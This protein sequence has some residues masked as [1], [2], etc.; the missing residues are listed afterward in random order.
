MII[1]TSLNRRMPLRLLCIIAASLGVAQILTAK[2]LQVT[3][4][5]HQ[6]IQYTSEDHHGGDVT[7]KIAQDRNANIYVASE[8]GALKFN[9]EEW[10]ILPPS[11]QSNHI[12]SILV[13]DSNNIW[14]AGPKHVGF[15]SCDNAGSY[16]FND[17]T[18]TFLKANKQQSPAAFWEILKL[19]NHIYLVSSKEVARWEGKTWK[20]WPFDD[21]R[22]ILPSLSN[23]NL[24]IHARGSGLYK[25]L[26]DD[27]K[28]LIGNSPEIES[29]IMSA[30]EMPN[31]ELLCA[32]LTNGLFRL[33]ERSAIPVQ[34]NFKTAGIFNAIKLSD[35]TIAIATFYRGILISSS[36]GQLIKEIPYGSPVYR[37]KEDRFGSIWAATTDSILH[38]PNLELIKFSDNAHG[39]SRFNNAIYY[40]NKSQLKCIEDKRNT[41]QTLRNIIE[42]TGLRE[43]LPTRE[44]LLYASLS[45][46]GTVSK[47]GI[48][49]ETP[50]PRHIVALY[51]SKLNPNIIY[52]SEPPEISRWKI[53]ESKL[54]PV[55][56][57]NESI[58]DPLSI[59]ELPNGKLLITG[60]LSPI[61]QIDWPLPDDSGTA[62][63]SVLP[64]GHAQGLLD[65]FIWAHCFR[66]DERVIIISNKGLFRYDNESETFHHDPALG[67]DLGNDAYG[68][69]SCPAADS[70]GWILRL[71]SLR[72]NQNQVGHLSITTENRYTWTPWQL[73][74]K[75]LAGKVEA[76]LHEQDNGAEILWV[77]GSKDLLRYDLSNMPDHPAPSTRLT[78]IREQ[79]TRQTYFNGAGAA[80]VFL[81]WD[82]PQKT[83]RLEYAAP[84]SPIKVTGYQTR[85]AG[86]HEAWSEPS[87]NTFREFTKLS[88]GDYQFEVRAVDEFGR[89]G[90]KATLS[91]TI[92][93]PW[94]KT[95]YAF[96]GYI[97]AGALSLFGAS[98][99]RSRA[100]LRKNENL[101]NLIRKKTDE[102]EKE[103]LKLVQSNRAKQNFL[104]SMSHEIRNPLNGILGIARLLNKEDA[105]QG[106]QS[107]QITH[108][109]ACSKH[110]HQLLGQ[111]LDYSSLEAGKIRTRMESFEPSTLLNEVIQMQ[112]EMAEAKGIKLI[113]QTPPIVF[114]WTGD[115]VFLR[116]ILVNLI[117]NGIKYTPSGSVCLGLT[118]Q[119]LEDSVLACFAVTDTG[120]GIPKDKKSFIFKEFTRLPESETSQLPGTG[121]GLAIS[122]EM[123]QLMGGTLELDQN[124]Q[125]GARFLLKV[126]FG[127]DRVVP[128]KTK[129]IE[130]KDKRVLTGKR[131]LIADDMD[132]NRYIS[133]E[134]LRS[135]GAD[136]DQAEDGIDAL[137]KLRSTTYDIAILDINMP[138]MSGPEAVEA[139]LKRHS[140]PVPDFIALSAYNTD[141]MESKCLAAGFNQFIEKPLDP[142]KL[143]QVIMQQHTQTV[144][145]QN[146]EV[147]L[148]AY[149][150]EISTKPIDELQ[151]EYRKSFK[152]ELQNLQ[153]ALVNNDHKAQRDLIH[154]LLGMSNIH[155]SPA[156]CELIEELSIQSKQNAPKEA[157]AP[158]VEKLNTAVDQELSS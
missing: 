139:F 67:S 122:S 52:S 128:S 8:S 110:L 65:K 118:Y 103:K 136:I 78:A 50:S 80:P 7:Y 19:K 138:N 124:H 3:T 77:G 102:L 109:Y 153:V 5:S 73:P 15:Y 99:Y 2:G 146:S 88:H 85:L 11:E 134:L 58:P 116:Q 61:L 106:K 120:T 68:L 16:H 81:E 24:Y 104:A 101:Q 96:C 145:S 35:G 45:N 20:I 69:E 66:I 37:I 144:G 82:F 84:P 48:T 12:K 83:L 100:L 36:E 117:S 26:D 97:A 32:T 98:R 93:P 34:S 91:F 94:N 92:L 18:E 131:V 17:L 70:D 86:F 123:A 21:T 115:P 27:F 151:K 42:Q 63:T 129:A 41:P 127:L 43:I 55:D 90:E 62:P 132:F 10:S 9:G 71:P 154:K 137:S 31:G 4:S 112:K 105:Q 108:L 44:Q 114:H 13:D 79:D 74:S 126:E 152:Q 155:K 49:N 14:I 140:G 29:G 28:L 150:S 56:S 51:Q 121:L 156:I 1:I 59:T 130:P 135:M 60:E 76:L 6:V 142:E 95:P 22:R 149:L 40:T 38:V 148:L 25:L 72:G 107:E 47:D 54:E 46:I 39:I 33:K 113:L 147:N 30:I 143:K 119:D 64:L 158:L 125:G 23:T 57:L 53:E 89:S 87:T 157:L 111:T 75:H 141:E 133:A